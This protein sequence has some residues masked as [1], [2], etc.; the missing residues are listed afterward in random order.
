MQNQQAAIDIARLS[1]LAEAWLRLLQSECP[2]DWRRLLPDININ[3]PDR[4]LEPR[5]LPVLST[6]FDP[7]VNR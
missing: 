6:R 5:S 7:E 3:S 1:A 2:H 4:I